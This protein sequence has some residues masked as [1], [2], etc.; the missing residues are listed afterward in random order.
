[1]LHRLYERSTWD[2]LKMA[3]EGRT[4]SMIQC[5]ANGLGLQRHRSL[6]QTIEQIREAK[7]IAMR[8][9]RMRN[10]QRVRDVQRCWYAANRQHVLAKNRSWARRHFF[11]NK[12]ARRCGAT[13]EQLFGLWLR[14]RGRCALSGR[15][16]D[17]TAHLDHIMPKARGG[18]DCISNYRWCSPEV[19]LMKRDMTDAEFM[20][21]C[22][23]CM[24]W[25]GERIAAVEA[26]KETT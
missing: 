21:I 3:F 15:R 7:R 12:A 5:K 19:N 26:E 20:D 13:A 2:E 25:I 4:R 8:E 10:P 6:K 9:S 14:Q 24:E 1:M 16:L 18:S 23:D 17:R 22:R 11:G